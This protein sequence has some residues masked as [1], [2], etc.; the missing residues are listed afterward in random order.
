[1]E[2]L[3]SLFRFKNTLYYE[4]DSNEYMEETNM[5]DC[6][7]NFWTMIC[8]DKVAECGMDADLVIHDICAMHRSYGLEGRYLITRNWDNDY[9]I[10]GTGWYNKNYMKFVRAVEK[11]YPNLCGFNVLFAE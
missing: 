3:G 4:V 2:T 11:K 8:L 7:N 5:R 9:A 10:R 1:M 6:F